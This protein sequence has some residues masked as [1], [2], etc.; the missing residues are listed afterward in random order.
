MNPKDIMGRIARLTHD[1][2]AGLWEFQVCVLVPG[3]DVFVPH[4]HG[5]TPDMV[6]IFDMTFLRMVAE[7]LGVTFPSPN[8][9]TAGITVDELDL[10][11]IQL[12][13]PL[14]PPSQQH[15][16]ALRPEGAPVVREIGRDASYVKIRNTW[17]PF[18]LD[19]DP[20]PKTIGVL[21]MIRQGGVQY[22]PDEHEGLG[23]TV[24]FSAL[25]LAGALPLDV[26]FLVDVNGLQQTEFPTNFEWDFGDGSPVVSGPYEWAPA[27]QYA[28]AGTY[29]VRL[30]VTFA[31]VSTVTVLKVG[32][33]T[34]A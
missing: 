6:E 20:P 21:T 26:Q 14:D 31:N 17:I 1:D 3:W 16:D 5:R 13:G 25:P 10:G 30:T 11:G 22:Q 29:D 19:Q 9:G 33:I 4:H 27:H 8:A 23:I 15:V 12:W 18:P 7:G 32:Y 24:D 34:A 28:I 2:S